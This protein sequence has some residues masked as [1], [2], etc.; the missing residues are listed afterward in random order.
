MINHFK[1]YL[2]NRAP[3]FFEDSAFYV[4]IEPSF[5]PSPEDE[6][7]RKLRVTLFGQQPGATGMDYRFYQFLRL[8]DGC[9][10]TEHVHRW[11]K[12]DTY[13]AEHHFPE[14]DQY[15]QPA[16]ESIEQIVDRTLDLPGIVFHHVFK[17]IRGV[18]PEYED[19]FR[20]I[21][22]S[23]TKFCMLL[24]AL[25]VATEQLQ[26]ADHLRERRLS[27]SDKDDLLPCDDGTLYHGW[28]A[29]ET[30]TIA[31][32]KRT[33]Q[34]IAC[35]SRRQTFE[36]PVPEMVWLYLA[37]PLRFGMPAHHRILVN[38]LLNSGWHISHADD[39]DERYV[40][41]RS[42]YMVRTTEPIKFEIL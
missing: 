7:T 14:T 30:L 26:D 11:D 29:S 36:M 34:A 1:T 5:V 23:L 10:L 8:I 21:T 39:F 17:L 32:I 42:I 12:R 6:G 35:N 9:H 22:D 2:C 40:I 13:F 20:T 15:G 37:W 27:H 28:H 16:E 24:F 18:A 33:C 25:G 31:A 19:G 38:G 41:L 4:F 3:A